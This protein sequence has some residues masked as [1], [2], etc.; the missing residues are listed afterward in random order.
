MNPNYALTDL[1]LAQRLERTEARANASFVDARARLTPDSGATW[2]DVAGT[3]AMFDGVGS[4]STQTFGFGLFAPPSADDLTTLETFFETRG[5]PVFHEVSPVADPTH[6]AL[7]SDRGYRPIEVTSVMHQP[8]GAWQLGDAPSPFRARP[9]APD[10]AEVWAETAAR[11][12]GHS[13]ELSTVM[14]QFGRISAQSEGTVCFVAESGGMPVATAALAIHGG[15]ALFAGASTLPEWRGLGA[16]AALLRARL[17]NAALRGCDLA[18]MC[19]LPGSAS[20]RNAEREGFRIAYTR[21][22]WQLAAR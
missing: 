10:E 9:I 7:L 21:T 17:H 13:P 16:Q 12:W 2:C 15:V 11:G 3:Y 22:K 6:L 20:Q 1:A 4:P 14:L 5:S 8:V 19:A 18:M